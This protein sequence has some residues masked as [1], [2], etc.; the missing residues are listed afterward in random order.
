MTNLTKK[1]IKEAFL[2]LLSDR[3]LHQI[4]IKDIVEQCGINRNSFYYHYQDLPALIEEI[5]MEEADAI[6][7][8]Y[9]SIDSIEI[10]FNVALSFARKNR[11]AILHIYNS[12]NRDIFEQYLWKV[13]D[14]AVTNFGSRAFANK[15]IN[16]EDREVIENFYKCEFF[17]F[18]IYWL[19]NGMRE[20]VESRIGRI[21]E[22]QHGMLEETINRCS[23]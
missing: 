18:A 17:G 20:D 8:E 4:T 23:K 16:A 1:A 15:E 6:I 14:Y 19:Q 10:A 9:P 22:L 3:P 21:F 12:V 7:D 13:S 11:T 5:V 2:E